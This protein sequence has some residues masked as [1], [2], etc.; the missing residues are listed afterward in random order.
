M[1]LTGTFGLRVGA[2]VRV[3]RRRPANWV[4]RRSGAPSIGT[5][6]SGGRR[7]R[8]AIAFGASRCGLPT[9]T[10]RAAKSR[11]KMPTKGALR[12][13]VGRPGSDT[14]STRT[15]G[16]GHSTGVEQHPQS[17]MLESLEAMAASLHFF[18]QKIEPLG[19]AVAGAAVVVGEDLGAP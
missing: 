6:S 4:D 8:D 3:V 1:S 13:R 17:V 2:R 15:G 12:V 9:R 16:P 18:H 14:W 10:R 19:R 7:T 11:P 5:V